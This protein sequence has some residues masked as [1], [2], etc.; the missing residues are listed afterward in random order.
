MGMG[1]REGYK[2][3]RGQVKFTPIKEGGGGG[4]LAMLKGEGG[5][6]IKLIDLSVS[7]DYIVIGYQPQMAPR[8]FRDFSQVN[9]VSLNIFVMLL[10]R[11]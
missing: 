6:F 8:A 4:I 5:F 7:L 3:T 1:E 10:W 9:N 2:I 11:N